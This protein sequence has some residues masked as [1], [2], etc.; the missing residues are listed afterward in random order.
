MDATFGKGRA[1]YANT[2]FTI[3]RRQKDIRDQN[4]VRAPLAGTLS[5]PLAR[6]FHLGSHCGDQPRHGP[7]ARS[8]SFLDE[9]D[10]E[11]ERPLRQNVLSRKMQWPIT[12]SIYSMITT[13]TPAFDTDPQAI[14]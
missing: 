9:F 12:P 4:V 11:Q 8:V 7:C 2:T 3:L 14:L 10:L 13:A 6:H 1:D 5:S